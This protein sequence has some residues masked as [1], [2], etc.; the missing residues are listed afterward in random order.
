[1][2]NFFNSLTSIEIF[3]LTIGFLGQGIFASRFIVQWIYSEKKGESSIPIV[4][5]YLSIFGGLLFGIGM[6]LTSGCGNKTL[7]RFGGGN[8][9]SLVVLPSPLLQVILLDR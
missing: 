8:L 5:W 7:I 3:F 2:I 9:K 1:M 6:T 4:F